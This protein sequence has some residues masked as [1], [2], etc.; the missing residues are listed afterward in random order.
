MIEIIRFLPRKLI[1][2][3]VGYIAHWQGPFFLVLPMIYFFAKIYRINL[4]ECENHW[5]SYPSLGEFFIRRLK[6]GL[7]P[8]ANSWAVHPADSIITQCGE[9]KASGELIQAKGIHYH[10]SDLLVET[11]WQKKFA[12]L[13]IIS[14]RLITTGFIRQWMDLLP[15]LLMFRVIF[16]Q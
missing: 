2:R 9:L 5:S 16:G 12:M 3:I 11:E 6:S 1:S 13:F 4:D 8:T 10:I 14:V 15:K 7:R